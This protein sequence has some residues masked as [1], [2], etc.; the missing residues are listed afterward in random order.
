MLY[1]CFT[2]I[3]V[4]MLPFGES[5]I[6]TSLNSCTNEKAILKL[7]I[8]QRVTELPEGSIL[9]DLDGYTIC[10]EAYQYDYIW[11]YQLWTPSKYNFINI[12]GFPQQT[13]DYRELELIKEYLIDPSIG[14][15]THLYKF[16]QNVK[17]YCPHIKFLGEFSFYVPKD[18]YLV[19]N[20]T[21]FL[22]KP[23]Y[24]NPN[25]YS[26]RY[27]DENFIWAINDQFKII[28][29]AL[30][31]N[32]FT[33]DGISDMQDIIYRTI[34][35]QHRLDGIVFL[36]PSLGL[37]QRVVS[38]YYSAEIAD[39]GNPSL[40]TDFYDHM[41]LSTQFT[42]RI[43]VGGN[44]NLNLKSFLL[45]YLQQ[46]YGQPTLNNWA[47][48]NFTWSPT[49]KQY[50]N[51]IIDPKN[52]AGNFNNFMHANINEQMSLTN[53]NCIRFNWT[54]YYSSWGGGGVGINHN[55]IGFFI[56]QSGSRQAPN[57][58]SINPIKSFYFGN[59]DIIEIQFEPKS[60]LARYKKYFYENVQQSSMLINDQN[61]NMIKYTVMMSHRD[62]YIQIAFPFQF[63]QI[64][65][66]SNLVIQGH[67]HISQTQQLSQQYYYIAQ[68]EPSINQI[69]DN[70]TLNFLI[71][72]LQTNQNLGV[73][74]CNREMV[75]LQ[76]HQHQ[77]ADIGGG[78]YMFF[79]N[80]QIWHNSSITLNDINVGPHQ[81]GFGNLISIT[82]QKINNSILYYKDHV[83][84]QE[85]KLLCC[86][87]C[88]ILNY[89]FGVLIELKDDLF[90]QHNKI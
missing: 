7:D 74:L 33:A 29:Y 34:I 30:P 66:N 88:L 56:I 87:E 75:Q 71:V 48:T 79:T 6:M 89:I 82:F 15:L 72:G 60:S 44:D 16:Q 67:R 78:I 61:Q 90:Y 28:P 68:I 83:F 5:L 22:M 64:F 42:D 65:K 59:R 39:Q 52:L 81:Y 9:E 45:N 73:G 62:S 63:S 2:I 21:R 38:K 8:R 13:N 35:S 18:S 27:D 1:L 54:G 40:L 23:L 14:S 19:Y 69:E 80:G 36:Q 10:Q 41:R 50:T 11:L 47:N 55:G 46:I 58:N 12:N 76:N 53:N 51:V 4:I 26:N 49:E 77:G 17:K 86:Y 25:I 32:Y 31:W 20:R 24:A 43:F 57:D 3:T 70:F 84:F 85:L 37:Y